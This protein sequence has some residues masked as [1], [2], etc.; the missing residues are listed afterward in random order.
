MKH[1]IIKQILFIFLAALA[2]TACEEEDVKYTTFEAPRWTVDLNGYVDAPNWAVDSTGTDKMPA[3]KLDLSADDA[4]PDWKAVDNASHQYSMTAIIRLSDFLIQFAH[5]DDRLAAFIDNECRGVATGESVNGV[6]LYFL[7]IKGNSADHPVSLKYYSAANKRIYE[8][9]KVYKFVQNAIHGTTV[10]PDVVAF[11][12]D[13]KLAESMSAVVGLPQVFAETASADDVLAAFCGTE[14]RGIGESFVSE[15]GKT[16][17][18]ID[19]RGIEESD[20]SISIKYYSAQNSLVYKSTD[21][22][23]FKNGGA[24]GTESQAAEPAFLP[25]SSMSAV[26]AIPDDMQT[27]ASAADEVAAFIG[28]E[29]AAAGVPVLLP[30]GKTVYSLNIRKNDSQT[31]AVTFRYYNARSSYMYVTDPV[32]E[33]VPE[34]NFGTLDAPEVLPISMK[35]KYPLKMTVYL[36]LPDY[37]MPYADTQDEL[38][39]FAGE[40][41]RGV[42]VPETADNGTAIYTVTV[43]GNPETKDI[44]FRYYSAR[45]AYM[46]QSTTPLTFEA[47]KV[48]GTK[49]NPIMLDLY[50]LQ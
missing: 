16:L 1:T 32:T 23:T 22:I 48:Y 47:E 34:L 24:F 36:A 27:A 8:L 46:Y 42:A 33:F 19:I 39:A 43:I 5:P 38:A 44:T 11:E 2:F 14:C 45:N 18:R 37:L 26:V 7:Y 29:I 40:D 50:N 12:K 17:Y 13:S 31:G 3:W 10:E 35:G 6:T 41:C 4:A 15:S 25:E 20:E 21:R 49:D 28:G 9:D 30:D